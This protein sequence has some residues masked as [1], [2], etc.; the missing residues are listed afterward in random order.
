MYPGDKYY[1]AHWLET[2]GGTKN[3]MRYEI[4]ENKLVFVFGESIICQFVNF[5][6]GNLAKECF[7]TKQDYCNVL[8]FIDEYT[9]M[10]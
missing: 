2:H 8:L 3:K 4:K 5:Y 7:I 1:K 6:P 10:Y 9:T